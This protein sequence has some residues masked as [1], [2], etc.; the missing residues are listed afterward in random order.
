MRP[1]ASPS[2]KARTSPSA[3]SDLATEA[4]D[5]SRRHHGDGGSGSS[6]SRCSA[7]VA[8]PASRKIASAGKTSYVST[9]PRISARRP[10][11][12]RSGSAI[13]AELDRVCVQDHE[14]LAVFQEVGPS[15]TVYLLES[16]ERSVGI[17]AVR[18]RVRSRSRHK[19]TSSGRVPS[20]DEIERRLKGCSRG[21]AGAVACGGAAGR[22]S[23]S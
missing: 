11:V 17:R 9:A 18:A 14:A 5:Q 20:A 21:A 4:L 7:V 19:P 16:F 12:A 2:S 6:T 13:E 15:P 10:V 3:S 23:A 8:S 1:P 22:A